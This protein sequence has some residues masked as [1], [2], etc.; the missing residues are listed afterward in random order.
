MSIKLPSSACD[1]G[2]PDNLVLN[3]V[4]VWESSPP[5][6]EE[7][8]E[9]R[10]FSRQTPVDTQSQVEE[11]IDGYRT[12]WIR[13]GVLQGTEDGC[14]YEQS[15]LESLHALENLLGIY[16]AVAWQL[17]LDPEALPVMSPTAPHRTS[18]RQLS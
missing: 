1:P 6:G 8:V 16:A 15:Q 17:L 14:T 4:R 18:S 3:V 2:L 11:I 10:L 5:E 13:R 9:W 12:R 7:P